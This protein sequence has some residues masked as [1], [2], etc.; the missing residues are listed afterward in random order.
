MQ[1]D[2][3][4]RIDRVHMSSH[5]TPAIATAFT[6]FLARADHKAV[7]CELSPPT[8]C[9]QPLNIGPPSPHGGPSTY[10]Y[11]LHAAQVGVP[12]HRPQWPLLPSN[13]HRTGLP[14]PLKR[15]GCPRGI[16]YPRCHGVPKAIGISWPFASWVK[17]ILSRPGL[18][19]SINRSFPL[20][21]MV[22]GDAYPVAGGNWT[23]LTIALANFHR[24]ARSPAGLGVLSMAN[25]DDKA[26]DT[27]RTLWK[28]N[29][30]V[31][32]STSTSH[33]F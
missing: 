14:S 5:L 17:K 18:V 7:V 11:L 15:V 20:T 31:L 2:R 32:L 30:E 25:G 19:R 8:F 16:G 3:L 4:R 23:P 1:P 33:S 21:C 12:R 27:L 22:R 28:S 24:L 10:Y 26:M 29:W 9:H 13:L 6:V